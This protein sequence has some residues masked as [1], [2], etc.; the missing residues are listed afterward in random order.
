M[1]TRQ[2]LLLA[3]CLLT[4]V[5][6]PAFAAE[7]YITD[8]MMEIAPLMAPPPVKGSPLDLA[9]MQAVL[10]AQAHASDARKAQ[11]FADSDETVYVMFTAVLGEKF[12]A[13]ALPK[14]SLMFERIGES[15]DETLDPAK[16]AFGRVRPWLANPAVKPIAKQTKSGSYPSGHTTRVTMN[17]AVLSM[18]VPEKRREIWARAE[19]Y[20]ESR[21]IGGMHYPTDILAGWRSGTAMTAVLMQQANFRADLAAA[22]V[23]L[24]A[25][26]GLPAELPK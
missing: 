2:R 14:T 13:A 12:N 15:E 8:K 19:D 10:D 7:P 16:P 4:F 24:R 21:V 3:S 6:A 18:M 26:L 1:N 17:A 9:D 11:A 25:A 20:A 5:I 23:E 22:R